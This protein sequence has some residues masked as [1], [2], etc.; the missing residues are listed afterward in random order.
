[1]GGARR[2]EQAGRT[3]VSP[4]TLAD[5]FAAIGEARA[6]GR[7]FRVLAGNTGAGVYKDWPD[8]P[9]LVSLARVEELRQVSKVQVGALAGPSSINAD[10]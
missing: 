10:S 2:L 1:M 7:R 9:V 3:W 5:A 8:E 4:R 6:A